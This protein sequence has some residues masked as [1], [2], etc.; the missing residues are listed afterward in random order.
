MSSSLV[1]VSDGAGKLFLLI[2]GDRHEDSEWKV[3][4]RLNVYPCFEVL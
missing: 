2:T 4:Q 3:V 1:A